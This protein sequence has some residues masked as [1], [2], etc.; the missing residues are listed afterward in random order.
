MIRIMDNTREIVLDLLIETLEK[1]KFSHLALRDKLER[2]NNLSKIDRNFITRLFEGTLERCLTLDAMISHLSKVRIEKIKPVIRNLLRMGLY[3]LFYMDQVPDF[4]VCNEAVKLS[5]KRGFS[6][7]SGFVNGILRSAARTED[8]ISVLI[9][10]KEPDERLSIFYSVPIWMVKQF[11]E[12]FSPEEVTMLFESYYQE[13]PITIRV[14]NSKISTDNLEQL[15]KKQGVQVKKGKYLEEILYLE[16]FESVRD[17]AGFSEGYFQVQDE[18][19]ALVSRVAALKPDDYVIDICAAP[20]GKTMHMADLLTLSGGKGKIEARDVSEVKLCL[21]R[22]NLTRSGFSN[23]TAVVRDALSEI[24]ETEEKADVLLADLPCSGLGILSKK[25]DIKYNMNQE[26]MLDLVK[27]QRR[28]LKNMDTALKPGGVLIFSTCTIH[29]EENQQNVKY[30]VEQMGFRTES[31]EPYLHPALWGQTAQ[32]GYVQLLPHIHGTDG[33]F[34][35]RLVKD[36][37]LFK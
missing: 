20:G 26:K 28:I 13:K 1:N 33:F 6:G 11:L 23:V 2:Y 12:S 18:S 16:G 27:L 30:L 7:L 22:E 32:Q 10:E 25:P 14:N 35:A 19:S 8:F 29:E 4:A 17:L 24:S 36:G 34:I 21:L 31:L 37:G 3:Q 5:R 15:L 9:K